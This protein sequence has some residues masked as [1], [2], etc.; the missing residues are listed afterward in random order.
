MFILIV[1]IAFEII[2]T[3]RNKVIPTRLNILQEELN[4]SRKNTQK[5]QFRVHMS[6]LGTRVSVGGSKD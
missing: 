6:T 3:P 4:I 2:F 5:I 1:G